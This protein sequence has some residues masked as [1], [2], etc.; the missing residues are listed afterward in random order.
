[1]E[2]SEAIVHFGNSG[3]S[4]LESPAPIGPSGTLDM[5]SLSE[6]LGELS[7]LRG[8]T[9]IKARDGDE[10][11]VS[12]DGLILFHVSP[13]R[14]DLQGHTCCESHLSP[15]E[16]R[17]LACAIKKR[18]L[19][20]QLFMVAGKPHGYEPFGPW[21]SSKALPD[22]DE[23]VSKA[24]TRNESR[25][26]PPDELERLIREGEGAIDTALAEGL[27]PSQWRPVPAAEVPGEFRRVARSRI[28]E[29]EGF[30]IPTRGVNFDELDPAAALRETASLQDKIE[31]KSNRLRLKK[32]ALFGLC[33]TTALTSLASTLGVAGLLFSRLFEFTSPAD[34]LSGLGGCVALFFVSRVVSGIAKRGY[35]ELYR[36][37]L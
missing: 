33:V 20:E 23:A 5:R 10:Y 35:D 37:G 8:V 1:M 31:R 18:D 16:M 24:L 9:H 7:F 6:A 12:G 15:K 34:T 4:H 36:K 17:L 30:D 29:A 22:A 14:G 2:L 25:L 32:K 11:L 27:L 3:F 26:V 21:P 13:G 19:A 28:H